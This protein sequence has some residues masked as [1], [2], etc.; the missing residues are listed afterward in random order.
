LEITD[1][2]IRR[3][4]AEGRLL[5][6]VAVTFDGSFVVHNIKIISGQSG[7]FVAMPSRRTKSGEYKD[8]AHPIN[9]TFRGVL[10]EQVLQAYAS[11]DPQPPGSPAARRGPAAYR[12][13]DTPTAVVEAS[14]QANESR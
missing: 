3:T 6:Y 14:T 4:V 10:Q 7:P 5:A 8:I 13:T 12:S 9:S 2:R 11:A 1:I